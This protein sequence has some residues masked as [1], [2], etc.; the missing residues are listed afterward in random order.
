MAT[1]ATTLRPRTLAFARALP[2]VRHVTNAFEEEPEIVQVCAREG[3]RPLR[4]VKAS[5]DRYPSFFRTRVATCFLYIFALMIL[6]AF[7]RFRIARLA[8]ALFFRFLV[9][10]VFHRPGSPF[11][12]CL[13]S[14]AFAR[15]CRRLP[16]L[17]ARSRSRRL[18]RIYHV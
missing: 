1:K 14:S 4:R 9:F 10:F 11:F 17:F 15:D 7:V 3:R 13:S 5:L 8:R 12:V 16:A 18:P 6:L 2:I